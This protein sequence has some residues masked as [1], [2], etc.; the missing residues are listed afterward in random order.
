MKKLT[1][2]SLFALSLWTLNAQQNIYMGF[3]IGVTNDRFEFFDDGENLIN[4]PL[5]DLRLGAMVG[6]SF[7]EFLSI[8]TGFVLKN[9]TEGFGFELPAHHSSTRA[10]SI[11]TWQFPL[12]IKPRI[13]LFSDN[14][15]FT[16]TIGFHYCINRDHLFRN[17]RAS[18]GHS[19]FVNYSYNVDY[20]HFRTFPLME[21][22]LGMDMILF[23]KAKINFTA[24]YFTGF[25]QV[26]ELDMVYDVFDGPDIMARGHSKGEYINV[27][28][29][30][31]Y[32]IIGR[33]R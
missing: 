20:T 9:Y 31:Y 24:S 28:I 21:T 14:L 4:V 29:G 26:I 32:P 2:S 10:T 3:E 30:I 8:E 16:P 13:K 19:S 7:N 33:F 22:G 5:N 17:E 6:Y 27:S 15:F 11:R 1:I 18:L 25:K 23:N 12:R